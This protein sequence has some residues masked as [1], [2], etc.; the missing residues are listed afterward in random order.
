[1][2]KDKRVT[3]SMPIFFILFG[4]WLIFA[5]SSMAKIEGAFP[6]MIGI[7]T[8]IVALY[9]L[10]S[11]LRATTYKNKFKDANILKVAMIL[12]VLIVYTVLFDKIGYMIDTF[13]LSLFTMITLGYKN[14]MKAAMLSFLITTGVFLI[15]SILLKVP[16]PTLFLNI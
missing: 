14:K 16:L 11:D 12:I 6:R 15:F 5:S 7:F 2:N 8:L 10:Y 9:Q 4:L 3:L 13:L 1:M